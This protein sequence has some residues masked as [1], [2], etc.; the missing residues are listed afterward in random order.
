MLNST[1][2]TILAILLIGVSISYSLI[3]FIKKKN[4][5]EN[6]AGYKIVFSVL[7]VLLMIPIVM[8]LF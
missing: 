4:N 2:I 5:T 8:G 3:Y 6:S 1:V 7:L